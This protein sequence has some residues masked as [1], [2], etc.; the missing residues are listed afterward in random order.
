MPLSNFYNCYA[1]LFHIRERGS[2]N[3]T[4]VDK[5]LVGVGVTL[6]AARSSPATSETPAAVSLRPLQPWNPRARPSV[7]IS[8]RQRWSDLRRRARGPPG[9]RAGP[10]VLTQQWNH[11]IC[12]RGAS[13]V[14]NKMSYRPYHRRRRRRRRRAMS[15]YT[16]TQHGSTFAFSPQ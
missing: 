10:R 2:F 13:S 5:Y 6:A 1:T 11:A 12:H 16:T 9:C 3:C 8:V 15:C 14:S 4:Q 7:L